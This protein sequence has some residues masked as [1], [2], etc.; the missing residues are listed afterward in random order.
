M[1]PHPAVAARRIEYCVLCS[2]YSEWY[3]ALNTVYC[4]LC[5]LHG[6]PLAA[7]L[8]PTLAGL[9]TLLAATHSDLLEPCSPGSPGAMLMTWMD[10]P[11]EKPLVSFEDMMLSLNTQKPTV[12]AD[13]MKK[14]Q[15]FRNDFGQDG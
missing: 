7:E 14:L 11:G 6:T 13:D 10:V 4:V 5:I 8:G 2:V 15:D 3:V 1:R 9:S 12:N